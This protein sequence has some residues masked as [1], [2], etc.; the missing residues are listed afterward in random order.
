MMMS[1]RI[2]DLVNIEPSH[3]IRLL[4]DEANSAQEFDNLESVLT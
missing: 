3:F 1:M 2:H 4:K